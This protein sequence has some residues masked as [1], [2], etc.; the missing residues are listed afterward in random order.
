MLETSMIQ[1]SDEGGQILEDV[2]KHEG[3]NND[4][5]VH[6]GLASENQNVILSV[7][8]H[9]QLDF[10]SKENDGGIKAVENLFGQGDFVSLFGKF[11]DSIQSTVL[12]SIVKNIL[13]EDNLENLDEDEKTAIAEKIEALYAKLNAELNEDLQAKLVEAVNLDVSGYIL[14]DVFSDNIITERLSQVEAE[15]K[16]LIERMTDVQENALEAHLTLIASYKS[17]FENLLPENFG[18]ATSKAAQAKLDSI[19]DQGDLDTVKEGNLLTIYT[20][21]EKTIKTFNSLCSS[22]GLT[23]PIQ[24]LQDATLAKLQSYVNLVCK[25]KENYTSKQEA[26]DCL[27]KISSFSNDYD[28]ITEETFKTNMTPA[29]Q[30]IEEQSAL[31]PDNA[32][33]G[34]NYM[35]YYIKDL[36]VLKDV[37][38]YVASADSSEKSNWAKDSRTLMTT[39]KSGIDGEAAPGIDR[40]KG[41]N[42]KYTPSTLSKG[43]KLQKF[44]DNVS[45]ETF[46]AAIEKNSQLSLSKA[47]EALK[48]DS[49][50]CTQTSLFSQR[51]K[52]C[53]SSGG[54]D[55]LSSTNAYNLICSDE[56]VD[57]VALSYHSSEINDLLQ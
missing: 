30:Y 19:I 18:N 33:D 32:K 40:I 8:K 9:L 51:D 42:Q 11:E 21:T 22:Y 48:V 37:A 23:S 27:D 14:S 41:Y 36:V 46:K 15:Q 44:V 28:F 2:L 5:V 31:S 7:A 43:S 29:N 26:Q 50:E 17:S 54:D 3:E 52:L 24:V 6:L 45:K 12:D 56:E 47:C 49:D 34:L 16:A 4:T 25:E 55:A 38:R 13:N 39:L 10:L 20:N 35:F 57:L 53:T 1:A